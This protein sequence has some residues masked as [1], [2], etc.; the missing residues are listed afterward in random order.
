MVIVEKKQFIYHPGLHHAAVVK[1][2]DSIVRIIRKRF[3]NKLAR[4]RNLCCCW[5]WNIL[6]ALSEEKHCRGGKG[7]EK[8]SLKN[9]ELKSLL[10]AERL[11]LKS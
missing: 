5:I 7:A 10:Y 3:E 9:D 11:W 2:A 1:N 8:V 4:N 6:I